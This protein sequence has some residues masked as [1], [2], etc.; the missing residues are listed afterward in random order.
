MKLRLESFGELRLI[1]LAGQP[2]AFPEKGLLAICY[3]LDLH[4]QDGAGSE[5]PRSAL[6]RFLWDSHD[7]QSAQDHIAHSGAPV[8][9][10]RRTSGFHGDRC[11]D[12][13]RCIYW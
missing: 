3:L 5:Y 4:M 10:R 13:A 8:R 7:N 12:Q 6:A 1:D 11:A 2:V 9:D